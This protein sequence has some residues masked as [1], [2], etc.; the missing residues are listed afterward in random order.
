MRALYKRLHE[1]A[2]KPMRM[3]KEAHC[4]DVF[5]TSR[6]DLGNGYYKYGIGLAIEPPFMHSVLLFP[7]SSVWKTGFI[8]TNSVGVGDEDYR[9]E[10]SFVFYHLDRT[11]PIYEVGDR[12]GQIAFIKNFS[13][14]VI[15]IETDELSRTERGEGGYGS[16]GN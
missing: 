14:N 10:Y 6:E 9:G 5:A 2:I 12:I 1:K 8:L 3:S 4:F 16:T 15:F 11:K 7:R 13:D